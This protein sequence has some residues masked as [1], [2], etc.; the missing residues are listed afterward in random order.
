MS[1]VN[2][3]AHRD[4]GTFNLTTQVIIE[5]TNRF[6]RDRALLVSAT[7]VRTASGFVG[8]THLVMF[9]ACRC[10]VGLRLWICR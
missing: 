7:L 3:D 1:F 10:V 8:L 5:G 6:C 9:D 2:T 4:I